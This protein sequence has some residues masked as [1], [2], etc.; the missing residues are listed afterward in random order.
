MFS[1]R[2][3]A[4]MAR[5]RLPKT[6]SCRRQVEMPP[7]HFARVVSR[8]THSTNVGP[9]GVNR[10]RRRYSDIAHKRRTAIADAAHLRP[11]VI[12]ERARNAV[13]RRVVLQR[14]PWPLA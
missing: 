12:D 1:N 5:G 2:I 10:A 3:V 11:P 6:S 8:P 4:A 9:H 7:G 14:E 13:E